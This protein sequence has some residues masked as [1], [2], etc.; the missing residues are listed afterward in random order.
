M[1]GEII[2]TLLVQFQ[3]Q[4]KIFHWQTKSFSQH[5]AF[6]ETYE[7]LDGLI[8]TFLETYFGKYGR[9]VSENGFSFELDNLDQKPEEYVND[10]I[11]FLFEQLPKYLDASDTDLINIRDEILGVANKLKYLLTLS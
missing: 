4:L 2:L 11:D 1:K 7:K 6:G 5:E 9:I 10:F 3:N 8:D